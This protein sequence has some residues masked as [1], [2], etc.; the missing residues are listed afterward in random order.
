MYLV[1][2]K[3]VTWHTL[4]RRSQA[5]RDGFLTHLG[6]GDWDQTAAAAAAASVSTQAMKLRL[7]LPLNNTDLQAVAAERRRDGMWDGCVTG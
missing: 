4:D 3:A 7:K 1:Y 2:H 5:P 6:S